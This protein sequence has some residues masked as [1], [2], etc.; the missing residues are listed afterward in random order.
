VGGSLPLKDFKCSRSEEINLAS[1]KDKILDTQ[2]DDHIGYII[3]IDLDY[4][5]H[6]Y[7]SHNDLPFCAEQKISPGRR[8]PKL[9]A[10]LEP[11]R[12]CL[13]HN[14]NLK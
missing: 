5:Q 13:I 4:P 11:K 10:T 3:E 12:N 8:L 6:L 1:S 7:E 9:L 14:Q 2:Q